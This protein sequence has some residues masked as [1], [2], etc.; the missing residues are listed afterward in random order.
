[1]STCLLTFQMPFTQVVSGLTIVIVSSIGRCHTRES[2]TECDTLAYIYMHM[3]W[4][5]TCV[6]VWMSFV[7]VWACKSQSRPRCVPCVYMVMYYA[8]YA[9]EA[10]S[11]LRSYLG[12]FAKL[13]V[14][15]HGFNV[16]CGLLVW[17]NNLC[18]NTFQGFPQIYC[19]YMRREHNLLLITRKFNYLSCPLFLRR[20]L[21]MSLECANR[22]T[23]GH[24]AGCAR[25]VAA[26][27]RCGFVLFGP[28]PAALSRWVYVL[29]ST[30]L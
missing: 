27:Q 14:F 1:M 5:A 15:S 8:P 21:R 26:L 29:N 3:H 19:A 13:G 23:W 6:D 16:G 4:C 22:P 20:L 7:L 9:M 2:P 17:A 12:R 11:V 24:L 30:L 25:Q 28:N 10:I 18:C